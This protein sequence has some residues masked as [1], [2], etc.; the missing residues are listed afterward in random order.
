MSEK[1]SIGMKNKQTNKQTK[2]QT[3][4]TICFINVSLIFH[5]M[6]DQVSIGCKNTLFAS[7]PS[8]IVV[9]RKDNFKM[10]I[11]IIY[12]QPAIL[13]RKFHDTFIILQAYCEKIV[14]H[15]CKRI[16]EICFSINT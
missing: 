13:F 2:K 3:K 11:H 14:I 5:Y 8:N 15:T 6:Y 16:K 1:F 12:Y 7:V 4:L 10:K 9:N